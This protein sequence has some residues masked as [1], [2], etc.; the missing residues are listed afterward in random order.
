MVQETISDMCDMNLEIC[1]ILFSVYFNFS[2]GI[3]HL[4]KQI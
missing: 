2:C 4:R 3:F 1:I